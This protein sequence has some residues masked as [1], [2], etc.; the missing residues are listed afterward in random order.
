[1]VESVARRIVKEGMKA[2][3]VT[4]ERLLAGL[5]RLREELDDVL[6]EARHEYEHPAD[7]AADRR[8]DP[9]PDAE[10]TATRPKVSRSRSSRAGTPRGTK[11]TVAV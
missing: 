6:V 5:A 11:T 7:S 1:M 9:A 10:A 8:A 2:W 4:T 3:I